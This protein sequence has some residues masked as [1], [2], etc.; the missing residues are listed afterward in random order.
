MNKKHLSV[1][2]AG[3]ML[4]TT[5]APV[6]AE[7]V[8]EERSANELGLLQEE[9]RTL[10]ESARFADESAN[11]S[12]RNQSIYAVYIN[13]KK[14]DLDADSKTEKWQEVFN[15]LRV[16][17]VV[18]VFDK[19]HVEKD[20]KNYHY[21]IQSG[22]KTYTKAELE[23][24][25]RV[26]T[27]NNLV[28]ENKVIKE[29][30]YD[31]TLQAAVIEFNDD[32]KVPGLEANGGSGKTMTLTTNDKK[33]KLTS[34]GVVEYYKADGTIGYAIGGATVKPEEFYGFVF[35]DEIVTNAKEIAASLV[36]E[37]TIT[38]GGYNYNVSD[39]YDGLFLTEKGNEFFGILKDSVAADRE[40]TIVINSDGINHY[41]VRSAA[42]E[43]AVKLAE[44]NIYNSLKAYN[45]VYRFE[46]RLAKKDDLKAE[47]YTISGK[48]KQEVARLASWMLMP[49]ARVDVLIK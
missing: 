34:A 47:T 32:T 17:D 7:V 1:V 31:A 39:L 11:K 8:K 13:N 48:D 12:F 15:S 42:T 14:V 36:K 22:V 44:T 23:D 37:Y 6:L 30:K 2:M 16:G 19:G 26:L 18:K 21:E 33:I 9:V 46:V 25:N 27:S 38:P 10:V 29:V 49:Q 35:D 41:T 4:A 28:G 45:G 43:E 24:L 20:G 3:A 40:A 5:V